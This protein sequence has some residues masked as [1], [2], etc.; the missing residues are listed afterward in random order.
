MT[1]EK[2]IEVL[3]KLD[4]KLDIPTERIDIAFST[5]YR[6]DLALTIKEDDWAFFINVN[7]SNFIFN[8]S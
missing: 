4:P 1:I 6:T 7:G 2:L 3:K 8:K 5:Y